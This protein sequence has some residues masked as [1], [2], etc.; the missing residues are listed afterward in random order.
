[1]ELVLH[2]GIDVRTIVTK[3][4]DVPAALKI[5]LEEK[6]QRCAVRGCDATQLLER[7]HTDPF[8]EHRTTSYAILR[9]LCPR[10]HDLVTY[11]G[12]TLVEHDDGSIALRPPGQP[13]STTADEPGEPDDRTRRRDTDA[14]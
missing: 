9:R 2:A 8:G 13:G 14:A 10:H 3:T 5:A 11:D 6:D 12:Y 7:H 4:R 1:L